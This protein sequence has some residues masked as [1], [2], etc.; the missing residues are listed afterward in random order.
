MFK[1]SDLIL[2]D[3]KTEEALKYIISC[4]VIIPEYNP[5]RELLLKVMKNIFHR[6]HCTAT[7]A[8]TLIIANWLFNYLQPLSQDSWS[9]SLLP[10]KIISI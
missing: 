9:R 6:L 5:L 10:M 1:R 7:L 3:M 2:V 8:L 4:G